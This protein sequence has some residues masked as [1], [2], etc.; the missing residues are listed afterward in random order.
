[1]V[2]FAENADVVSSYATR[3]EALQRLADLVHANPAV[4][5]EVGLRVYAH[6]RAVGHWTPASELLADRI[7]QPHLV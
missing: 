6:G 3:D 5:D 2:V 1:V 7:A 4:Q